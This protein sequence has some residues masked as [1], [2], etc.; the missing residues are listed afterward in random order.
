MNGAD[1]DTLAR[2][3][4]A[5]GQT[6]RTVLIGLFSAGAAA[7]MAPDV[8]AR[9]GKKKPKKITICSNGQTLKV[10]KKGWQSHYPGAT[11]GACSGPTGVCA[12]CADTCFATLIVP[13]QDP[14]TVEY[15]CCPA[16]SVCISQTPP[17]PD[18]CCYEG[19]ACDQTL[20]LR[21][22]TADM[23]CC[24]PA[25]GCGPTKACCKSSEECRNGVCELAD[26]ARLPRTRRPA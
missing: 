19:D 6:R 11:V 24:R 26:T 7:H 23:I 4:A 2:S 12:S 18:Q 10:R 16:A 1:L 5:G 8:E 17:Y 3:I 25:G 15:A 13:D 9:S 14:S 22:A 21:D 20:P